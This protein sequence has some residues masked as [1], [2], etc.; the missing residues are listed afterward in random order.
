MLE[1][2]ILMV[3]PLAMAFAAANDLFTMRI[4]NKVSLALLVGFAAAAIVTRAPLETVGMHLVVGAAA[5]CVTF[6]MFNLGAF[7]G[8][9]AKLLAA[10]ALWMGTAQILPFLIYVALFGGALA[11]LLIFYRK[12]IPA[13]GLPLPEW[14]QKLHAPGSGMPYGIAIAASGLMV[15]PTTHWYLALA[16]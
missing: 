7:G 13:G 9:D 14:A 6:V 15:Y 4:P 5:L 11:L 3:F 12:Y 10:G 8:G 1:F 2:L 16:H